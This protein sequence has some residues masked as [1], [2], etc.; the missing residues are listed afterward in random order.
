M[1]YFKH[2]KG[3]ISIFLVIILVPMMM[4]SG[5][6]VDASKVKL[7]NGVAESAGDLTLN[8]ALTDY[9]TKLKDLYG[10][11]ATAQDTDELYE[12]LEGYYRSCITSSGVANEDADNFVDM[13]MAQL[14]LTSADD[15]TSDVLNM[16]LMDFDVSKRPD[17]SLGKNASVVERQI[18]DFMKYRAPINTGLSFISSLQSFSTL[19]EQTDLVDKRQ[20][21][22]EEQESVMKNA[23]EAWNHIYKYNQ[24]GYA[25]EESY[26]TNLQNAFNGYQTKLDEISKKIIMDL[27][28]AQD[29]VGFNPKLY[30]IEGVEVEIEGEKKTIPYF[31]LNKEKTSKLT[32]YNELTIYSNSKKATVDNIR[33]AL[34]EY[35]TAYHVVKTAQ[36]ELMTY[37][38]N[39]YGQQ[40]LIQT[41][42]RQLYETWVSGMKK[43]YE[44]YSMLRHAVT[45]AGDTSDGKSIMTTKEKMF[46]E[47]SEHTFKEYYDWCTGEGKYEFNTVSTVFNQYLTSFNTTLQKYRNEANAD[48]TE[49]NNKIYAIYKEATEYRRAVEDGKKEIDAAFIYLGYVYDQVKSGGTLE[50][51]KS[52]WEGAASSSKLKNTSMARQDLAEI[53]SLS[54]YLKPED[55]EK[56][57]TRLSNISSELGT[58]LTQ[59]DSYTYFGTKVVEISDYQTFAYILENKIGANKL[60]MVPTNKQEL[61]QQIADWCQNQFVIGNKIDVS[62]RTQSGKQP[63]LA[64]KTDKLNFYTYLFQ[65]FNKATTLS[66][67]GTATVKEDKDNGENLYKDTKKKSSDE[68]KGKADEGSKGG[69]N[70]KSEIKDIKNKPS[71]NI[72]NDSIVKGAEKAETGDDAVKNTSS[73]LG[74]MLSDLAS[75]A[76]NMGADLRDKLYVSDYILSM[77]SYDTIE[78]EY[79]LKNP[80]ESKIKLETLTYNPIDK[81]HNVAYGAEVEYII[82][83]G[84]NSSN[85]TK[86]Y[87]SIYGIRFGFNLIYA[88]TDSSIR[89]SALAIATPISAATMG[90]IPVP[91]IQAAIIIGIGAIESGIDLVNLKD[92]KSVPL[93]K[94]SET[95]TCSVKGLFNTVKSE[96]GDQLKTF[97]SDGV[98]LATEKLNEYL[99]MTDEQLNKAIDGKTDDLVSIVSDSYDE[100]ITRHVNTTIQKF[101]TLCNNAIEESMLNPEINMANYVKERLDSWI[102]EEAKNSGSDDLA[103]T[104]KKEAIEIIKSNYIDSMLSEMKNATD[105]VEQNIADAAN[106]I[107][108]LVGSVRDKI[109]SQILKGSAKIKEYK[110]NLKNDFKKSI[111]NG[112]ADLKKTLNEKMDG[113]FGSGAKESKDSTG[114]ASLLNFSYKDYLRLFLMIGLCAGGE[115]GIILRTSDVIQANMGKITSNENYALANSS[116]YVEIKA[117]IQVKPTMLALPLFADVKNN[118]TTNTG[119]YTIQYKSI[120]GY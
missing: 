104:V 76:M 118:P 92:G 114:L 96:V 115:E 9:D 5:F 75:Q 13:I 73:S 67:D 43:L 68:A 88:F 85:I 80:G 94:D 21:Y 46:G 52:S 106:K 59:I 53:D 105:Q 91:L 97:A 3:A 116:A 35:Y 71:A 15:N 78:K 38:S 62:W 112:S 47:T 20:E 19:S 100:M 32:P 45:Y 89:D 86:T 65:H 28:D 64:G 119:W 39:T 95:W 66:S 83:G 11:F 111:E 4:L 58:L 113:I 24:E 70:P 1:K 61:E 99:D 14:Q 30:S 60:K 109:T 103:Y 49:T 25:K 34:N 10:L 90:V 69:L 48:I 107:N 44:K 102:K 56:L 33:L 72:G 63:I 2:T 117:T 23:E 120:K 17:A 7:A 101:T 40:Y 110:D 26:L 51:K 108:E 37:D 6:F 79:K 22:Y 87:A 98:D 41:N 54:T 36:E 77:F 18:V 82:W 29:Y 42:R 81:D 12:K 57:R 50:Q 16:Q 31:Y 74:S 8:T 27:Y 84:T 55:V 93:F